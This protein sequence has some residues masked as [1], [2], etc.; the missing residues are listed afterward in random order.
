MSALPDTLPNAL[1]VPVAPTSADLASPSPELVR[2]TPLG[3]FGFRF[4]FSYLLIYA[5]GCGNATLWELIPKIGGWIS[6]HL[7]L[8][9]LKPAEYLAQHVFHVTGAGAHIHATGSGDTAISW[10]AVGLMI[11][12]ALVVALLWSML[13]RRRLQY[14]T[15]AAWLRFFLRLTLV[16][17]MC[18]YGLA[19]LFPLQMAPPS[20][21][22][23]NE[24][25]GQSS[26]MTLLWTLIGLNPVYEMICGA[27]EV[28]A[29]ALLFFRRTALAGALLTGFVMTNVLLYNLFFDVPVKLY[30]AHLVL[31]SIAITAPDFRALIDFFW[32]HK[33]AAP[34]GVWVPPAERRTFRLG[35]L[36]VEATLLILVLLNVPDYHKGAA[37][38][39]ESLHHPSPL[40]GEWH[41][42]SALL[43][44]KGQSTPKPILTGDGQPLTAIY[45]EPSGRAMFRSADGVLWRGGTHLD[46]KK[47]TMDVFSMPDFHHTYDL[48]Q[49]DPTHLTLTPTGKQATTD[50]TLRLTRVPL[51]ISYPLLNRGFHW[52]NEWGLE[53]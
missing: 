44:T 37:M 8:T 24:P 14:Q 17:A 13:D 41:L 22:V 42:D 52:V 29:A 39:R 4:A 12:T 18:S 45:L 10:I 48:A 36:G 30:A 49:P 25:L 20:L 32:R 27:A 3:R 53:R 16:F 28:T 38:Q 11:L 19:K 15:A 50:P 5:F 31:F 34:S 40:T 51:P 43:T 9:W 2:W 1:V 23:L 35:T 21:A 47:H 7:Y 26:P 33:P 6:W 46:A